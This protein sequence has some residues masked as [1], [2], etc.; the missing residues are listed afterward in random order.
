M[1]SGQ[2]VHR[3]RTLGRDLPSPDQ[4]VGVLSASPKDRGSGGT[5]HP[6]RQSGRGWDSVWTNTVEGGSGGHRSRHNPHPYRP[7]WGWNVLVPA[8]HPARGD[9]LRSLQGPGLGTAGLRPSA[10]LPPP[11]CLVAPTY[12]MGPE[13]L[14]KP[15]LG[16]PCV[17]AE[18]RGQ[19]R[20]VN[21]VFSNWHLLF[22]S[23]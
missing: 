17:P 6:P 18:V 2:N 1:A 23:F 22:L 16:G 3:N 8:G 9:R 15:S 14:Q 10:S 20:A 11:H 21:V 13:A 5:Q 19:K 12:H 4:G 7:P